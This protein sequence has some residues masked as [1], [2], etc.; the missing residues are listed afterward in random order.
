MNSKIIWTVW[1]ASRLR[2]INLAVLIC[3][4]LSVYLD[5]TIIVDKRSLYY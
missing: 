2:F 3:F 4:Y 1:I 5:E